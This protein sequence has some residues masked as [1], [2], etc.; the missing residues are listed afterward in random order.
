MPIWNRKIDAGYVTMEITPPLETISEALR[1]INRDLSN[2]R[3]PLRES[4]RTVVI[5]SID[6]NFQAGGRPRWW[7]LAESTVER[8]LR[9]GTGTRVLQETGRLRTAATQ[10]SRWEIGTDEAHIANWPQREKAKADTH[11]F[12]NPATGKGHASRIPARPF[13]ELQEQDQMA[14]EN[15]FLNWMERRARGRWV[16]R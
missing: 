5:P 6:A 2:M 11:Q 10:F 12:G 3:T 8:R 4:V 14:I 7:P 13:L 1:D 16:R 15:V 9:Q